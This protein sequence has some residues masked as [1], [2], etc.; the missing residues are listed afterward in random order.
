MSEPAIAH[1]FSPPRRDALRSEI[2]KVEKVPAGLD[3]IWDD[4][5]GFWKSRLKHSRE[6][7]KKAGEIEAAMQRWEAQ[8]DR[9][10]RDALHTQ[11]QEIRR[12]GS[13]WKTLLPDILPLLGDLARRRLGLTPYR[14]QLMGALALAEGSLV[15]MA[16]GE[17]KT[18]TIALAA[19][20]AAWTGKPCHVITANDYLARRDAAELNPFFSACGVTAKA[21]QAAMEGAE[22][23]QVYRA[24]VVYCTGKELVAD[25]L[26]DQLAL[27]PLFHSGRRAVARLGGKVLNERRSVLRGLHTA[28][29][30]EV[31]NQLIDEAVTPLI[32]SRQQENEAL[33]EACQ[34]ADSCAATLLPGEDYEV[35]SR[36]KE[37]TLRPQGREA[38]A[39]FCSRQKGFL[40]AEDWVVDL[41]RQSL[42]ARH[43]FLRDQQY[44]MIDGKIVIV[45]EFTGR[46]MPGRSWRLGL[47]QAVEAKEEVDLSPPTET[48]AQVSFQKF[49]RFFHHLAGI[50]GT[51]KE[52]R[53]EFWRVYRL[54]LRIVP[55]HRPNQRK[56][57]PPRFF[58]REEPKWAAIVEEIVAIYQSGRPVLVGTRSVAASEHLARLLEKENLGFSILNAVRHE[59]EAG[60]VVRAGN[61]GTITIATNMAGR[62][63]DI[64][65][66]KEAREAGGLHVILTEGHESRRI[67]R[68]LMGRAG[69]QGDP[70]STRLYSAREDELWVRNQKFVS[71]VLQKVLRVSGLLALPGA[72]KFLFLR[73]Q[74]TAEKK[75]LKQRYQLIKKDMEISQQ[76]IG[77]AGKN[78]Q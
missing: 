49:Y 39:E 66:S 60:I 45:D 33:E 26:R 38:V 16:T 47:H 9:E 22:R 31:D 62:G 36:F 29:V 17:G 53:R 52:G 56:D 14:T 61:Q 28:I 21:V 40:A 2:R 76:V 63:T 37:V 46:L 69:R 34:A 64:R 1:Q 67:D 77:G 5:K 57:L 73:T 30:D 58:A 25:F 74:R 8:S 24:G 75:A 70:G 3:A 15:E 7:W 13:H 48:L 50:T 72:A 27:G 20:A 71:T 44:V 18:L 6:L 43:F 78:F 54:P 51:A 65:L 68:Q 12:A 55:R 41:V 42:Q 35:D 19:A 4:L 23:K 11:R 10:L 32:I 59:E